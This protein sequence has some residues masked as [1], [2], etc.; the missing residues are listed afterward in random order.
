MKI[1]TKFKNKKGHNE[2]ITAEQKLDHLLQQY[3]ITKDPKYFFDNAH[4]YICYFL[5]RKFQAD[6]D[7]IHDFYLYFYNYIDSC[8]NNYKKRENVRFIQ[9]FSYVIKYHFLNFKRSQ[10]NKT[11][12]T[13]NYNEDYN[14]RIGQYNTYNINKNP[15]LAHPDGIIKNQREL[16]RDNPTIAHPSDFN[17]ISYE[18]SYHDRHL[19]ESTIIHSVHTALSFLKKETAI[20]FKLYNQMPL[21]IEELFVLI[22]QS[23]GKAKKRINQKNIEG[24]IEFFKKRNSYQSKRNNQVTKIESRLASLNHLLV[25]DS[26]KLNHK[27]YNNRKKR[28]Q[29]LEKKHKIYREK[30]HSYPL[31]EIANI[32]GI[33]SSTL[34]RRIEKTKEYLQL[35]FHFHQDMSP[36]QRASIL[37][38]K[39]E[40][41]SIVKK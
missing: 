13:S 2:K 21:S 10:R 18:M 15:H 11:L 9:F 30:E 27:M 32:I 3:Q 39:I 28:K 4:P 1:K 38:L 35:Y 34:L 41:K 31:I 22:K 14:L 5:K 33:C 19:Y 20:A 40:F 12:F 25:S 26:E 7:S 23:K 29:S 36:T 17:G 8:L 6:I 37:K 24:I 16:N